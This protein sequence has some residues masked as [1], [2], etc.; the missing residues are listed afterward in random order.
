MNQILSIFLPAVFG[1]YVEQK[2]NKEK[3][4]T[5]ECIIKYFVYVLIINIISY[6][7]SIYAF[8]KPYFTFTN[9]FTVKYLCLSSGVGAIVSFVISYIEKNI[10]INI[11]VDKK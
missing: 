3:I 4:G 11:R 2:I 9:V 5:K 7:I 6:L 8:G 1:L 10:E